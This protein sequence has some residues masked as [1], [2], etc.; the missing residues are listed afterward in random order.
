MD[1]GT[2]YWPIPQNTQLEH[3]LL[4]METEKNA[5]LNDVHTAEK[6]WLLQKMIKT[7]KWYNITNIMIWSLK[8]M[9]PWSAP[10]SYPH[11]TICIHHHVL[12]LYPECYYHIPCRL[13]ASDREMV[14]LKDDIRTL[15]AQLNQHKE[16]VSQLWK[17]RFWLFIF[18]WAKK[19]FVLFF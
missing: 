10:V 8:W 3:E 12:G 2:E 14:R 18:W 9:I 4:R 15:A 6:R 11:Q 17:I 5:L 7:Y 13:V 16:E 1:Y 19:L